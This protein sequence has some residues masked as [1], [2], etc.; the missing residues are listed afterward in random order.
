MVSYCK[1]NIKC[2][3]VKQKFNQMLEKGNAYQHYTVYFGISV[4][5]AKNPPHGSSAPLSKST[6]L[7]TLKETL[8][9][10]P[11]EITMFYSACIFIIQVLDK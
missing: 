9:S 5:K 2:F 8:P 6:S 3:N 10:S 11:C 7:P 4:I 1:K